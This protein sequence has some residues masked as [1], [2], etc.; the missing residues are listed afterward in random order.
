MLGAIDLERLEPVVRCGDTI[1]ADSTI[2]LFEQLVAF[3]PMA[4]AFMSFVT[5]HLTT[6]P[7]HFK[8]T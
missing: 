6:V 2:A 5:T 7:K 1:N 8:T 3:H 4:V